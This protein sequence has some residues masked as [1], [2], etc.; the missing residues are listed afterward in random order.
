MIKKTARLY[1]KRAANNPKLAV[2][3]TP[4]SIDAI[5]D[6]LM[7]ELLH[8][9][10]A[11]IIETDKSK[12]SPDMRIWVM[13]L[14]NLFK[15]AQ[16]KVMKDPE[17]AAKLQKAMDA[18]NKEGGYL[19]VNEKSYYYGL[20]SIHEFISMIM[21]DQKFRSFMNNISYT[22]EKSLLQRFLDIFTEILKVLGVNVKD[23][24]VLK[25]AVTDILGII[26]SR[27]KGDVLTDDT[28]MKSI[29]TD[30]FLNNMLESEF[31]NIIKHLDI[32]TTKCK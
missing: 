13:A 19:S 2:E 14:E 20:T 22:G 8:H 15:H 3:T 32:K 7:H 11:N 28:T 10:T 5:A 18:V 29:K 6:V 23:N 1:N 26:E 9:V 21:S 17:H 30:T 24:S 31:D 4:D 27:D 16:E 25:E 12:L